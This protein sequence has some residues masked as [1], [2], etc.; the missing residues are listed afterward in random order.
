MIVSRRTIV[1]LVVLVVSVS[2]LTPSAAFAD[3]ERVLDE[4]SDVTRT[5][6]TGCGPTQDCAEHHE[7]ARHRKVADI[8]WS[9]HKYTEKRLILRMKLRG[10]TVRRQVG[11]YVYW[12]IEGPRGTGLSTQILYSE[13]DPFTNLGSYDTDGYRCPAAR[14]TIRS[15]RGVFALTIPKNCLEGMPWV[16]VAAG[17][18][19]QDFRQG[20]G[21]WHDD[22]RFGPGLEVRDGVAQRHF[23]PRLYIG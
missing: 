9:Q 23:G 15:R 21:V 14:T 13:G 17:V 10:T 12:D 16:R 18:M 7:T 11:T 22:A 2:T 20:G 6:W 4:T 8:V 1:W 19:V 3:H 5:W